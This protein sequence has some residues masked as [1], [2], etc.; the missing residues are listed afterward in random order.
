[1][2]ARRRQSP[3]PPRR[4]ALLRAL[5]PGFAAGLLI[6][7]QP[8]T[9]LAGQHAIAMHGAP[10][11]PAGF[12]HFPYVNPDAPKGGRMVRGI[13]G[14]FDSLNPFI[15]RGLP[16]EFL[17]GYVFESL[18]AR[19]YD[20]PF[21][22]YGLLARSLDTDAARTRVTFALDPSARFAD[23]R[24]VTADDVVFSWQVLRDKGRP[25]FR[26]YYSKVAQAR[27]IDP[28][29]VRFDFA[30]GDRELPLILGLM[31]ILPRHATDAETFDRTTLAP[32]LGSGPYTV[33]DIRP[34]ESLTLTRN[35]DYWGRD[36]PVNRGFWNFDQIRLDYYRDANTHFE[37]FKR[38]LYDVRLETDPSRWETGFDFPAFHD[39][40]IVKEALPTGLPAGMSGFVF[41]TRRAIFAD[42]RV[43]EAVSLLFDF[44]WINRNFYFGLSRRTASYFASSELSSH[45]RPASA[46]E[47][48]L[49]ASF[50]GSVRDDILEG[51]WSPPHTDGSARDRAALHRALALFAAAGYAIEGGVLRS[52]DTRLP[53]AFEILVVSREQERLALALTRDL[54]RAGVRATVRVV[55][56]VQYDRRR[57]T[58]DFDMLQN[59]WSASLS[60]GNEQLFY[61]SARAADEPGTRNYMGVRSAAVDAMIDAMLRAEERDAFVDAVRALDRV[62]LSG[63]FVLPLFHVP[64]QWIARWRYIARP[65]VTSL[66]GYL[67][68]TWWRLA[69][70]P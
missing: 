5:A 51:R 20:E 22:L 33:S 13:V 57:Q 44:E 34:G 9:V 23:G 50:P 15:V 48:A 66:F 53:F 62:L 69:D 27:A 55:D 14:T 41:N 42:R 43:R 52:R 4:P 39:G 1:M 17:R 25:N 70:T 19:G 8:A 28:L 16:V 65:A 59:H 6:A 32:P 58:Y 54:Q 36:V 49:L 61:W 47:R 21:T 67:P 26:T 18:M 56:A 38:G 7:A 64:D 46:R 31:P 3:R 60:P 12:A 68:E 35:P 10:A 29:T 30:E 2:Q 45:G 37:A 24:P 63:F 11:L 40:R